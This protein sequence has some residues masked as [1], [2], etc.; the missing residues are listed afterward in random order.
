VPLAQAVTASRARIQRFIDRTAGRVLGVDPPT[1]PY[2]IRHVRIPMRDGVELRA[3]HYQ[4]ETERP[5]GT[6]LVRCPYGRS[7]P[8]SFFYARIYAARGYHVVLQSVRG[9][10]GSGGSFVPMINEAADAADTVQWLRAQPW[11]AGS[12]A[13]IGLSY[14][15]FTQWALLQDP[16]P[17]L[18]A[19]VITVGP[20]D[21][22]ASAWGTGAFS[23][24]DFLGWSDMVGHQELPAHRRL[25]F[26]AQANRRRTRGAQGLPLGAA[27]RELLGTHAPWYESWVE[28][29]EVEHPFWESVSAK[30]A[31][32][33]VETPVLLIGGWQDL[34]LQQTIAQY[35][36]LR[37]RGVDV[38]MTIGPWTHLQMMTKAAGTAARETLTFLDAHLGKTGASAAHRPTHPVRVFATGHG[39]VELPDWP[40][41]TGEGVLYL[42][43]NGGLAAQAPFHDSPGSTFVYDPT[44]PTPSVG[45]R[46]LAFDA[47]YRDDGR[48]ASRADVLAFTSGPLDADLYVTGNPIVELAHHSDNPHFDVFVRLSQVD[49]EGRSRNISDGF[50][51]FT[52]NPDGPIRLELDAIAHRFRAGN[53]LRVLVA[54]GAHPRFARNLGTGEPPITGHRMAPSTHT[55]HHGAGGLSRLL[56]PAT[57]DPPSADR[58]GDTSGDRR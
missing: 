28:H 8:F 39:W 30:K 27:G 34:F 7:F 53:R 49:D 19:A 35:H 17:E 20:H 12:F 48:L 51:R 6:I 15:G 54:G 47:G 14:L 1:G 10:F 13:T 42:Q 58:V 44:D 31:L 24:S 2:T 16:P 3:K 55:V 21:F 29:P 18:V 23:L 41:V 50:Q 52:Q 9:T 32:D 45:G 57:A 26:Q 40:P 56:L 46:L 36:H 43:P 11:F 37:R 33:C 22:H 38:A 25:W 5:A 4:P